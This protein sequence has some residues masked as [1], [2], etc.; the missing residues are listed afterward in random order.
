MITNVFSA[1][2]KRSVLE[3]EGIKGSVG[4]ERGNRHSGSVL[5]GELVGC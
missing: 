3:Q 4:D 1:Q 5:F 2:K